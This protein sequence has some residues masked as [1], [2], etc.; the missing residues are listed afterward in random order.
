VVKKDGV[1]IV[2]KP[3]QLKMLP[4]FYQTYLRNQVK[5]ADYLTLNILL[6]LLQSIKQVNLERLAT[7]LPFPIK[8]E[9]R[10]FCA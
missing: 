9:S 7:A 2:N 4:Q 6:N 1:V 3:H 10:F 8:F 5:L